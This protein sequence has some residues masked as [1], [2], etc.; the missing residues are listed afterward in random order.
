MSKVD[1][2]RELV[3]K[4]K[5]KLIAA[6]VKEAIDA[7]EDAN[8][9]LNTG[10]IGAMDEVGA[11]FTEGKIFVPEMLVAAKA[12]KKGVEA[13]QPYLSAEGSSGLG[14]IIIGTVAGDLHDIGK[15]LVAMMMESGGFEVIDLGVDV[16]PE[17]FIEAV[18]NNPDTKIVCCSAL[19]TTTMPAIKSTIDAFKEAGIRDQV[20]IMI[21]G[22]P[23]TQKYCE[24]V[25]ADA[26][27][28]DAAAAAQKAKELAA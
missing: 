25:G 7:G 24:E 14:K 21:G 18:K 2:I 19:L 28:A 17:K 13:L 1:E 15:N 4:G 5:G 10:M 23:V 6:A 8:E 26:Y 27:T 9:L 12:M 20:K 22:A 16:S 11:Q 3:K